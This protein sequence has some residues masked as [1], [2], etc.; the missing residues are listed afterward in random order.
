[1]YG[2]N[3][4]RVLLSILEFLE[5][6]TDPLVVTVGIW[7]TSYSFLIQVM[8]Y[9]VWVAAALPIVLIVE[10]TNLPNQPSK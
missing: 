4:A 2:S 7:L 9:N 10:F 8:N 5:F 3:V 6:L 1:M